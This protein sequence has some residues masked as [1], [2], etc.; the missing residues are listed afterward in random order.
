MHRFCILMELSSYSC[1]RGMISKLLNQWTCDFTQ[2]S[3]KVTDINCTVRRQL[4]TGC[5]LT[6]FRHGG[7]TSVENNLVY[8]RS[9]CQKLGTPIRSPRVSDIKTSYIPHQWLCNVTWN[10]LNHFSMNQ[11]IFPPLGSAWKSLERRL[12][13]IYDFSHIYVQDSYS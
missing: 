2:D 11:T 4:W 12:V 6:S 1:H 9:I 7:K 10:E 13:T 8:L 3:N 5:R